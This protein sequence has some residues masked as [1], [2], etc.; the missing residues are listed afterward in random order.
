MRNTSLFTNTE[1]EQKFWAGALQVY[2]TIWD[3]TFL[4]N[5][6]PANTKTDDFDLDSNFF[7][8]LRFSTVFWST[9]RGHSNNAWYSR[10]GGGSR[11]CHQ[12]TQKGQPK[13]HVSFFV[14]FSNKLHQKSL[15]KA[16]FS[17][18]WKLSRHTGGGRTSVTKLHRGEGV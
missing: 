11:Q 13:Y 4:T 10:G 2:I 14:H 16:M 1:I 17:E 9:I 15:L 8:Y 7:S 3:F 18:K 5:S 12:M 6:D